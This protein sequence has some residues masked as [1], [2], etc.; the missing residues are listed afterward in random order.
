MEEVEEFESCASSHHKLRRGVH[1]AAE[2]LNMWRDCTSAV[3]I[4]DRDFVY[5]IRVEDEEGGMARFR[6]L[7]KHASV[8]ELDR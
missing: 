3:T 4:K 6:T 1:P 8:V 5:S 2:K 7:A